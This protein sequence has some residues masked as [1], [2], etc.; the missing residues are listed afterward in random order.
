MQAL[1][2][3]EALRANVS[4]R[5]V[6]ECVVMASTRLDHCRVVSESKPGLGFGAAGLKTTA[7]M[8]V[9]PARVNGESVEGG[10]I[11]VPVVFTVAPPDPERAATFTPPPLTPAERAAAK[12]PETAPPRAP[13]PV[14]TQGALWISLG[15]GALLLLGMPLS[16]YLPPLP[17]PGLRAN[18]RGH[19]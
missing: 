2:P 16:L 3:Q 8:R 9:R 19:A 4:G 1:F 7:L 11:T 5:A 17:W 12:P 13:P 15:F 6:I 14:Q 10:T 18:R